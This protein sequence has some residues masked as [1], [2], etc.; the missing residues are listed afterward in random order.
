MNREHFGISPTRKFQRDSEV[1]MML[2]Y[3]AW[4]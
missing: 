4:G 3:Y 2:A 1:T